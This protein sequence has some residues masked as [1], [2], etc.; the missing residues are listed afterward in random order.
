MSIGTAHLRAFRTRRSALPEE[1]RASLWG[2]RG[3][4]P[5]PRPGGGSRTTWRTAPASPG[6]APKRGTS[7]VLRTR[8]RID[9][10]APGV[11]QGDHDAGLSPSPRLHLSAAEAAVVS[12]FPQPL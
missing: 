4:R 11:V 5:A 9:P 8:G 10:A 7:G 2:I 3:D 1:S 6:C 12:A